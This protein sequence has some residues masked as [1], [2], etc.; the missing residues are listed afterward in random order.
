MLLA[1]HLQLQNL[2]EK[3]AEESIS[4]FAFCEK[5]QLIGQEIFKLPKASEAVSRQ[6]H[7]QSFLCLDRE[8]SKEELRRRALFLQVTKY[9]FEICKNSHAP[10]SD[11]QLL[12][13]ASLLLHRATRGKKEEGAA[14][15]AGT[16]G[17]KK[18]VRSVPL[19]S[20]QQTSDSA[21][22]RTARTGAQ[23]GRQGFSNLQ[24]GLQAANEEGYTWW[25]A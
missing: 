23:E 18:R 8:C 24:Q 10:S 15:H 1:F 11:V 9:L 6:H 3:D 12:D 13:L 22:R 19:P 4:H 2:W 14:A 21:R 20:D 7:L 16:C 25:R 5:V 17:G